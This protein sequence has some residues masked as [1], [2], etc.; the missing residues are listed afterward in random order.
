MPRAFLK[1]SFPGPKTWFVQPGT[2]KVLV[3]IILCYFL[4]L[5]VFWFM[6]GF[7]MNL[8]WKEVTAPKSFENPWIT[9]W[10]YR[11]QT[12]YDV[13]ESHNCES[14]RFFHTPPPILDGI[15]LLTKVA[16]LIIYISESLHVWHGRF[17]FNCYS[18][19]FT[20]DHTKHHTLKILHFEVFAY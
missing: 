9:N 11:R 16:L 18:T 12:R 2:A 19:F 15:N 1:W 10:V 4:S 6:N 3:K 17:T 13:R 5:V 20:P 8:L 14:I 7:L